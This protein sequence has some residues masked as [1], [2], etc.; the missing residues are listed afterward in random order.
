M[1]L[2]NTPSTFLFYFYSLER[3]RETETAPVCWFTRVLPPAP[4][5]YNGAW[6][7]IQIFHVNGE[8]PSPLPFKVCISKKAESGAIARNQTQASN[9]EHGSQL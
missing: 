1:T 2:D 4:D 3:Q 8:N 6:I 7:P 9:M 5:G